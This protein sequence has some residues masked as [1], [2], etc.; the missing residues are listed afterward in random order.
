[1]FD[2][3]SIVQSGNGPPALPCTL[4]TPTRWFGG[5]PRGR[6]RGLAWKKVHYSPLSPSSE[7]Y[8]ST[9]RGVNALYQARNPLSLLG[10]RRI[11]VASPRA[12]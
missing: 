1:M 7:Q 10:I 6:L 4:D 5:V 9:Y 11:G 8:R 2:S 3:K 12:I